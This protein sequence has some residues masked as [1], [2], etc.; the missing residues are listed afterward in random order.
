VSL[1]FVAATSLVFG[2]LSVAYVQPIKAQS[3]DK[4]GADLRKMCSLKQSDCIRTFRSFVAGYTVGKT[5]GSQAISLEKL[6]D[7]NRCVAISDNRDEGAIF[8]AIVQ[9][10]GPMNWTEWPETTLLIHL[11]LTNKCK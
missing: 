4:T 3:F 9:L 7:D 1:R 6:R 11:V 2:F 5:T 10:E 8:K